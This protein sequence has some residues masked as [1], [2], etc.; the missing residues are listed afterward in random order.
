M[1][2]E[3]ECPR[4]TKGSPKEG[5]VDRRNTHVAES[6]LRFTLLRPE[7]A[8][9]VVLNC[10][11]RLLF[12][13]LAFDR[14]LPTRRLPGGDSSSDPNQ[15]FNCENDAN[16]H[17]FKPGHLVSATASVG[18]AI[19]RA[20]PIIRRLVDL[21]RNAREGSQGIAPSSRRG[22]RGFLCAS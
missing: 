10:D 15:Q 14:L 13:L 16:E 7:V 22:W 12:C 1:L 8:G 19:L 4:R 9:V 21:A 5:N 20:H 18:E 11:G 2:R 6:H 17:D 3:V